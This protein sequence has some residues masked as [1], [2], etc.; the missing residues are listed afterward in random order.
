MVSRERVGLG[1]L[2]IKGFVEVYIPFIDGLIVV[3]CLLTILFVLKVMA[4]EVVDVLGEVKRGILG[5]FVV[6]SLATILLLLM[7]KVF[8]CGLKSV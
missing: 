3:S 7:M 2:E 6:F 8:C 5:D 1:V 4:L